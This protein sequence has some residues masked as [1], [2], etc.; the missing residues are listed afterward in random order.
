MTLDLLVTCVTVWDVSHLRKPLQTEWS[1]FHQA[2]LRSAR[3][4]PQESDTWRVID[5][6]HEIWLHFPTITVCLSL[7][8]KHSQRLDCSYSIITCFS[9]NLLHAAT[10]YGDTEIIN[11]NTG[12]FYKAALWKHYTNKTDLAWFLCSSC[13]VIFRK[14]QTL[15][16]WTVDTN[17]PGLGAKPSNVWMKDTKAPPRTTIKPG[18]GWNQDSTKSAGWAAWGSGRPN[19]APALNP[20]WIHCVF[21]KSSF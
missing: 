5:R 14:P 10:R 6:S 16:L 1:C 21:L 12:R 20:Q 2:G 4:E 9:S 11:T 17:D 15:G 8:S 13:K 19:P 7:F 18:C 3:S